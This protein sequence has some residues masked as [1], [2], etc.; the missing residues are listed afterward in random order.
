MRI[1]SVRHCADIKADDQIQEGQ[2]IV[3]GQAGSN[4]YASQKGMRGA[5]AVRHGADIRTE[6]GDQGTIGLQAG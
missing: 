6:A 5:G 3:G 1:G 2:G 4:L